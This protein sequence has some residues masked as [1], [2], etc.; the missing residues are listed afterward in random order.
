MILGRLPF[1]IDA[2]LQKEGFE[3]KRGLILTMHLWKKLKST[4]KLIRIMTERP[5]DKIVCLNKYSN[6][7]R[8]SNKSMVY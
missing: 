3:D 7:L 1:K 2:L 4:E 8:V 6:Q 5:P